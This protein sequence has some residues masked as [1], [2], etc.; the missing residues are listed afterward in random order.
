MRNPFRSIVFWL[1][2]GLGLLFAAFISLFALDVFGA[3]YGVWGT[4][5]ALLVHLIPTAAILLALAIGW[6]WAWAGAILFAALGAAYIIVA[7]GAFP[8]VTYLI[9]SG[10]SFL[11]GALFLVDWLGRGEPEADARRRE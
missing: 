9:V 7:W 3:G 1:P 5:A 4:V 10:P 2:R 8:W 11:I 6:R